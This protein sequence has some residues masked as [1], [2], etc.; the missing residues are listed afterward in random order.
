MYKN[1][2]NIYYWLRKF[3]V[4]KIFQYLPIKRSILRKIVFTSIFESKHWVQN[5]DRQPKEY[6]SISGHGS[7][8]N[9]KQSNNLIS[10][11]LIFIEK[12]QINSLLDMPC[13]D[14]L[15]MR[16]FLKKKSEIKYLGIDIVDEI[17]KKN[18]KKYENEK[19]KFASFD[20]INFYTE[21]KFDLVFMRDFF[22][23][24]NNSDIKKILINLQKMNID[25]FAFE[26]YDI[27]KNED[28]TIG[29]HRKINLKL[30]PFNLGEPMY[31]FKDYEEDKYIYFY[32]KSA[33]INKINQ[34]Q[35]L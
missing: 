7:N 9:T 35:S 2:F 1:R 25:Y 18:K 22:I 30:D 34:N 8:I 12:Y 28:V 4:S 15:W 3:Y 23:H 17:I 11:L 29:R 20:I 21:E 31:Y 27:K 24:I 10:S 13:G 5:G 16:E 6:I 19:V 26:N 32:K 14:F 33:L